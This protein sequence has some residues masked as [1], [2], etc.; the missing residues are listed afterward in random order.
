VVQDTEAVEPL[1]VKGAAISNWMKSSLIREMEGLLLQM[2]YM[3]VGE[4][5][6][7]RR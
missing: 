5:M 6:S 7:V 4:D 3:Q 2:L 1:Q